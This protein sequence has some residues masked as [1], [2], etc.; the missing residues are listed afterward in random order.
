MDNI[1]PPGSVGSAHPYLL[2]QYPI[3]APAIPS[4]GDDYFSFSV[5]LPPDA[6]TP[7]PAA[8]FDARNADAHTDTPPVSFSAASRR[9]YAQNEAN[10][11]ERHSAAASAG[12]GA[13]M[14]Q[15][16][17]TSSHTDPIEHTG[18]F[19]G[20]PAPS[21]GFAAP[22]TSRHRLSGVF[23]AENDD[24]HR[25]RRPGFRLQLK[26]LAPARLRASPLLEAGGDAGMRIGDPDVYLQHGGDLDT[27]QENITPLM[28][29][30]HTDNGYFGSFDALPGGYLL[31]PGRSDTNS[32]SDMEQ[33]AFAES[34]VFEGGMFLDASLSVFAPL[35]FDEEG[36]NKLDRKRSNNRDRTGAAQDSRTR[37]NDKSQNTNLDSVGGEFQ[38]MSGD[39]GAGELSGVDE[40]NGIA[41]MGHMGQ[42]GHMS[43]LG[44]YG[45]FGDFSTALDVSLSELG[46]TLGVTLTGNLRVALGVSLRLA[47]M[48]QGMLDLEH[49]SALGMHTLLEHNLQMLQSHEATQNQNQNQSQ[50]QNQNH[51]QSQSQSQIQG[52]NIQN[53][54]HNGHTYDAHAHHP[55]HHSGNEEV[56]LH[57]YQS[58]QGQSQQGQSQQSHGN[59][60]SHQ[61]QPSQPNYASHNYQNYQGQSQH[62]QGQMYLQN[63][64]QQM[65]QNQQMQ[66]QQI[67]NPQMQN[68]Q[69]QQ[70]PQMHSQTHGQPQMH[71]RQG[72]FTHTQVLPSQR[73]AEDHNT[74]ASVPLPPDVRI[75]P[76][77]ARLLRPAL[78]RSVS[79]PSASPKLDKKST[80]KKKLKGTVCAVCDRHIG[81]DFSRHM[82]IHSEVRRF[83]CLFPSEYCKHRSRNFNRPYDYKK[84]LLNTH[85]TFDEPEI[86]TAPNLTDKLNVIGLCNSCGRKFLGGEWL[87]H[88]IL[89]NDL[90]QKCPELQRLQKLYGDD[91][92]KMD[93]LID[94]GEG[95]PDR[96]NDYE[97]S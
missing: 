9:T 60:A 4:S 65:Q 2:Q 63:Q 40:L 82:R 32:N 49:M 17:R 51:N 39:Y 92:E 38:P 97:L 48:T 27:R 33:M 47:E 54:D 24:K 22:R 3:S 56:Q 52:Q 66:N 84:H 21:G 87:D 53:I 23:A 7:P 83:L 62:S 89:T 70:N 68:Q 20:A 61:S 78:E 90:S 69:M 11:S 74:Q 93:L 1:Y 57:Q 71:P 29:P 96:T 43:G 94:F 19:Y 67:Q 86:R 37:G 35:V 6:Q 95:K 55:M 81:R 30:P 50:G 85:F 15:V 79:E 16:S 80:K 88:H 91:L 75:S 10:P 44:E 31:A 13:E 18:A 28:N 8:I 76:Q 77:L 72:L 12:H 34:T 42:M 58:Q 46:V 73:N 64:H 26:S 45:D 5:F 41:H 36:E 59:Y 14:P 25:R